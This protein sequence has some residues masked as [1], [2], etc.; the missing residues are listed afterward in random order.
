MAKETLERVYT[1]PLRGEWVKRGR[2][3]RAPRCVNVVKEFLERHSKAGEV[4]LSKG[5]NE[6][7]W[8]G[9]AKKPPGKIK[10]RVELKDGVAFAR[11]PGEK[12]ET[13]EDKKGKKAKET[14]KDEKAETK[15][16]Q[17]GSAEVKKEEK[18]EEVKK[19]KE[20]KKKPTPE[21]E[22]KQLWKEAEEKVK[23]EEQEKG[24]EEKK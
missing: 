15:E 7:L 5:V 19:G 8:K 17:K 21:E 11:L 24:S 14:K 4:K 1:I 18:K 9:G 2:I 10:V 16:K 13:K 3:H 22:A 23:K 12:V 20:E 6:F